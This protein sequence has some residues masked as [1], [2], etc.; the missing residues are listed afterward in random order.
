MGE[1][2]NSGV[3]Q[4]TA[5]SAAQTILT[6][7]QQN[8]G[9]LGSV[10]WVVDALGATSPVIKALQTGDYITTR[11]YQFTADIAA[12]GPLG[13]GY[14][15]VRFVFDTSNGTPQIVYRQDL[16]RLGWALGDKVRQTWFA[17]ANATK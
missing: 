9:N 7:R 14:R 13:R 3:D 2:S 16:S 1:G 11:S 12:V 4:G 17:N 8:T 5:Q 15:R 6:Y 10:A